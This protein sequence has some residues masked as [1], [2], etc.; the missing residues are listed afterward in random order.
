MNF[1][2]IANKY[3]VRR[4]RFGE[5][6]CFSSLNTCGMLRLQLAIESFSQFNRIWEMLR[7]NTSPFADWPPQ[8][9]AVKAL[10]AKQRPKW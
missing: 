8:K 6:K 1:E 10:I 5:K 2:L 7:I 3:L 4:H 9:G